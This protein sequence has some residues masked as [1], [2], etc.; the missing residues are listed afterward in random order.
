[1][2]STKMLIKNEITQKSSLINKSMQKFPSDVLSFGRI[3][4]N[5]RM[6]RKI[7]IRPTPLS[8]Q[9]SEIGSKKS[10]F[11]RKKNAQKTAAR[12]ATPTNFRHLR[13]SVER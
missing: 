6:V 11:H 1:M 7:C 12:I 13:E 9:L 10:A 5:V 3:P 4:W 8:P 2:L